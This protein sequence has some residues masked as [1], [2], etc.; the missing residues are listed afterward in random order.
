MKVVKKNC[1]KKPIIH[2]S[3]NIIIKKR[4]KEVINNSILKSTFRYHIRIYNDI[5]KIIKKLIPLK[6]D[7]KFSKLEQYF[8]NLFKNGGSFDSY[9]T[10]ILFT[11]VFKNNLYVNSNKGFFS[12]DSK[13]KILLDK[14]KFLAI[15]KNFILFYNNN[16]LFNIYHLNSISKFSIFEKSDNEH[17][18]IIDILNNIFGIDNIIY[19]ILE[20]VFPIKYFNLNN[21][22][23]SYLI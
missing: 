8:F 21:I 7:C 18:Y 12:L 4:S 19:N 11:Y 9:F 22:H 20:F 16:N 6:K 17:C 5:Y 3:K 23:S 2:K 10:N 14:I 13:L 15:R 1:L